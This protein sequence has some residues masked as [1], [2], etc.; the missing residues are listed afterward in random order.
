V[1]ELAMI[2]ALGVL[3][4]SLLFLFLL[5]VLSRRAVRLATRRLQ[6]LVP[7]SMTEIMAER[8][9][10]R[11][12]H[13]TAARRLEQKLETLTRHKAEMMSQ[14][15]RQA[16]R[17]L[18]LE[19]ELAAAHRKIEGLE[20][21]LVTATADAREAQGTL[22]TQMMLLHDSLGLADRRLAILRATE[23]QLGATEVLAEERRASIAALETRSTGQDLRIR[24]ALSQAA[25]AIDDLARARAT[26]ETLSAE[27]DILRAEAAL[28]TEEQ[29]VL[30]AQLATERQK[31]MR[32]DR[33]Y[34][35]QAEQAASLAAR[36]TEQAGD[37]ASLQRLLAAAN[38]KRD[39]LQA[40]RD[41]LLHQ[42]EHA[43]KEPDA[44]SRPAGAGEPDLGALRE[45]ISF[46]AGELLRVGGEVAAATARPEAVED[47]EQAVPPLAQATPR[48]DT[49]GVQ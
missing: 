21:D 42:A 18:Q 6:M 8:D 19:Q 36:I 35:E 46:V 14:N 44:R 45:A 17:N 11:A 7:L 5:P 48:Q 9:Q 16:T 4:A 37:I 2:F 1:I 40:E 32:G 41:R 12:E 33:R 29:E 34:A 22:G 23:A 38:S 49:A 39:A 24:L 25:K 27:R 3:V 13:A 28:M 31:V 26:I 10:I 47:P 15:G 20:A 30:L 43:A